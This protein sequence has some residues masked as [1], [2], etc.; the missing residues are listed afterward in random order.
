MAEL[1]G[2]TPSYAKA[3]LLRLQD[4]GSARGPSAG[5]RAGAASSHTTGTAWTTIPLTGHNPA[6][7]FLVFLAARS[8][9]VFLVAAHAAGPDPA[10][11]F[12]FILPSS[13]PASA[14]STNLPSRAITMTIELK[15]S[16]DTVSPQPIDLHPVQ[17]YTFL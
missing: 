8:V 17:N 12:I 1:L 10:V 3:H 11:K 7:V 2:S 16:S 4:A 14:L 13:S 6:L 9:C 5:G 15:D